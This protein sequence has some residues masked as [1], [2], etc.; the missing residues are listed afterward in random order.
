MARREIVAYV[1]D[2]S[3]D[4]IDNERQPTMRFALDGDEYEIDLTNSEKDALR[5]ALREFIAVAQPLTPSGAPVTRTKVAATTTTVRAWA[6]A[7]GY[8]LPA[9]GAIPRSV[10]EAYDAANP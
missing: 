10:R 8:K 7:N 2:L 9:R 4:R 1:S 5:S 3:G 6:A